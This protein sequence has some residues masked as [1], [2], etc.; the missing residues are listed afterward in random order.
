MVRNATVVYMTKIKHKKVVH[1]KKSVVHHRPQ[2]GSTSVRYVYYGIGFVAIALFLASQAT[3]TQ[4]FTGTNVLGDQNPGDQQQQAQQQQQEQLQQQQETAQH[5]QEQ[6]Q[7]G[8]NQGQQ[9]QVNVQQNELEVQNANGTS[10]HIKQEDNGG[11]HFQFRS[12]NGEVQLEGVNDQGEKLSTVSAKVKDLENKL[13]DKDINIS[14][15]DGQ[16]EVEHNGV[17]ARTNFPL[18]I[19]PTTGQ[20]IVTT[21]AGTKDVAVLPDDAIQNM[22]RNGFLTNVASG[23]GTTEGSPSGVIASS[24]PITMQGNE[25]VYEIQGEKTQRLLG[26]FPVTSP[27]T[28]F[29]STQN[30]QAIGQSQSWLSQLIGLLS[31]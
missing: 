1:H 5:A 16:T 20:L 31:F 6:A 13:K 15:A 23:S 19:D 4:S 12:I 27:R 3:Y 26:L 8:G 22:L 7:Q 28:V 18:S 10:L 25:S 17:K 11:V 24:L 2:M 30:G 21:P 29:V 14:T 9:P